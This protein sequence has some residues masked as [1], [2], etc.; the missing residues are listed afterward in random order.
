ML[1]L[2]C[3]LQFM[4]R[5]LRRVGLGLCLRLRAGE[6]TSAVPG[7]G[8]AISSAVP[9]PG[10]GAVRRAGRREAHELR[11]HYLV[12]SGSHGALAIAVL[13]RSGN[14]ART[15]APRARGD[16]RIVWLGELLGRHHAACVRALAAVLAEEESCGLTPATRLNVLHR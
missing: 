10:G 11:V 12:G 16:G 7:S 6:I 5:N 13:L 14:P 15:A 2:R 1:R 4:H 8:G 9:R 3:N